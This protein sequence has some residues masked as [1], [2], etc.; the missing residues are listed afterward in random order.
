MNVIWKDVIDYEGLYKVS[1]LGRVKSLNRYVDGKNGHLQF[2][3]GII[4]HNNIGSNGYP[5]IDLSKN[6]NIKTATIHRIMAMVFIP[7]PENK[8]QINH[9]NSVRNDNR[10]PNLEWATSSE[11]VQHG[12]DNGRVSVH[13]GKFGSKS[14]TAKPIIQYD[15]NNNIITEYGSII[16]ASQTTGINKDS[17]SRCCRNVNKKAGN[18]KWKFKTN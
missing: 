17:I 4:L 1:N 9:K 8:S 18:Y 3:E 5:K 7:N 16:D 10:I 12:W 13:K 11:N 2:K 14:Q 15:L 6:G